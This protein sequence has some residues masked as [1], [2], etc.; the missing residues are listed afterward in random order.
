MVQSSESGVEGWKN[1][2][3]VA[4]HKNGK[5]NDLGQEAHMIH[6]FR[7]GGQWPCFLQPSEWPV[8]REQ[9]EC[10]LTE[11]E[12]ACCYGHDSFWH[13]FH[14][15]MLDKSMSFAGDGNW[16]MVFHR[17]LVVVIIVSNVKGLAG[18]G[19]S[20][21]FTFLAR[22]MLQAL[23]ALNDSILLRMLQY[24]YLCTGK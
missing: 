19:E 11:L 24:A 5:W 9:P 10:L 3:A 16:S 18:I 21:H 1:Q 14:D 2:T 4:V 20:I 6:A 15:V 7:T 17:C 22:Q 8:G 12:V 13:F 23:V